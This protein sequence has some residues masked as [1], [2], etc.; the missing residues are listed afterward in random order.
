MTSGVVLA[1]SIGVALNLTGPNSGT[2]TWSDN[3]AVQTTTFSGIERVFLSAQND[4]FTNNS[5]IG[6]AVDA[7]DGNDTLTGGIGNDTLLGNAGTDSLSGGAGNDLLNGGAANDTI[8]GGSGDD[9]L[10]GGAGADNLFGDAGSDVAD[11][12]SS[13]SLTIDMANPGLSTGDAANDI[14]DASVESVLGSANGINTF[15]GRNNATAETMTGGTGNDLFHGSLGSDSLN[16][17]GGSD[18]VDYSTSTGALT[19][20][21][22]TNNNTGGQADGDILSSI[23]K[24]IGS[25]HSDRMTASGAAVTFEG[26]VGNDTLTGGAG[27]DSLVGNAGND[28][29]TGGGGGDTLDLRTGNSGLGNLTGDFAEGGAGNDTVIMSQ[30]AIAGNFNLNGGDAAGISGSDTLQF[31]ASAG[32]ALDLGVIFSA[33]QD[34]KY[35][36][37][38]TLDLSRDNLVSNVKI[39]SSAIRALVDSGDSSVLKVN[40]STGEDYSIISESNVSTSFGNNSVSFFDINGTRIAKADFIF[41]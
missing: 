17:G 27:N 24:I 28:S 14:I 31:W 34:S 25:A 18:T 37:F 5:T 35:Q 29:L 20:N 13:G 2:G 22:L 8:R 16:G 32:G 33:G 11:Y 40:L 19:V 7:L 38:S 39:S 30:A 4:T 21:L 36:N 6:V 10:I 3:G 26:G 15:F 9:T 23:E 41:N 12:S 1:G